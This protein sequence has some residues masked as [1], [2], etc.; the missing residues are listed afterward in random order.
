MTPT[1][2]NNPASD[3]AEALRAMLHDAGSAVNVELAKQQLSVYDGKYTLPIK[4]TGGATDTL[5]G[6]IEHG[7]LWDGDLPSKGGRDDLIRLGL[8]TRIFVSGSDGYQAATPMGAEVYR[9]MFGNTE[10]VREAMENRRALT[11]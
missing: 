1:H 11:K 10:T 4:L 5:I 3:L 8:A 9:R 6:L 7:P 2:L